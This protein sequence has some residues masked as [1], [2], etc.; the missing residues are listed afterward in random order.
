MK[1]VKKLSFFLLIFIPLVLGIK[2]WINSPCKKFLINP[3]CFIETDKKELILSFD[4]GPGPATSALLVTLKNNDIKAIFFVNGYRLERYPKIARRI[5]EE[6]HVLAN[7][8][9]KHESMIFKSF[10][11]IENDML[12]TDSLIRLA[13]QQTINLYRPPFGKSLLNLPRVLKKHNK[14]MFNWSISPSAQFEAIY[15]R[16]N[17]VNQIVDQLHPGGII[18]LH[19]GWDNMKS[20]T[21]IDAV[22]NIIAAIK[23]QGYEFVLP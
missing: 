11:Y 6:G 22:D 23:S 5:V 9:Y 7:H 1:K 14:K 10:K 21:L 19:D 8:S 13:G 12:K 18:L 4:D 20:E 2:F 17:M 16:E 3:V 15:S